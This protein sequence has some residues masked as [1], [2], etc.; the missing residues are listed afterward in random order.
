MASYQ[1][2]AMS[3]ADLPLI[4]QW[5]EMPQ[6]TQWW[7]NAAKQFELISADLEH[8]AIDQFIIEVNNRPFA[9][10]QCY[11]PAAWPANGF[12]AQPQGTRGIDQF[13]GEADMIGRGHGSAFVGAFVD[14]QLT[15]GTTRMITD[16]DPANA[17]AIRAYEK[18]GF[19]KDRIVDTPNGPALLMVR[20]A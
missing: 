17:R 9:Y 8:S 19:R 18:A 6:V 12:G 14:S 7:G 2:R 15:A 11:D 1:F 5:L 4:R 16:P 10:L 20:Q 3:A 13:I